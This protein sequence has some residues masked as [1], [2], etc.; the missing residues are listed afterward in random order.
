VTDFS[1]EPIKGEEAAKF[2]K[3]HHEW[4]EFRANDLEPLRK[5]AWAVKNWKFLA[6]VAIIG[7]AGTA[8]EIL[9]YARAWW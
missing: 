5:V 2:R 8:K 6:L 4:V 3:M 9:D 1:K 7:A